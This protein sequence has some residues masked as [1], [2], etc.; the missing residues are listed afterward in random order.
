MD[1][2][3]FSKCMLLSGVKLGDFGSSPLV[4]SLYR[5]LVGSLLYL[6][7]FRLDLYYAVGDVARYMHETHE[8]HWKETKRILQYVQ[9]TMNSRV[10]YVASSP[11]ELVGFYVFDWDGNINDRISNGPIYLSKNEQHIISLTLADAEYRG[12]VNEA[13]Q[14]VWLEGIL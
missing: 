3:K 13:T 12:P 7:Y 2:C 10:H 1:E 14:C 8:I 9:G 11:L 4:N 6:T 5:Q